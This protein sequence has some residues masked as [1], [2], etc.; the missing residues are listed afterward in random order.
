[1]QSKL[2]AKGVKYDRRYTHL[3]KVDCSRWP[4]FLI[5]F[6]DKA[7]LTFFSSFI[8]IL[9]SMPAKMELLLSEQNFSS[10]FSKWLDNVVLHRGQRRWDLATRPCAGCSQHGSL[11]AA[12]NWVEREGNWSLNHSLSTGDNYPHFG[13]GVFFRNHCIF[14][15]FFLECGCFQIFY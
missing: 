6:L 10:L 9:I 13:G 14:I 7:S 15:F 12:G 2:Q 3:F 8:I 11:I 1:M 4:E 5:P